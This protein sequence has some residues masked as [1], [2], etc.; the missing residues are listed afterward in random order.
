MQI[1]YE[2]KLKWGRSKEKPTTIQPKRDINAGD[3]WGDII[4][5]RCT[6]KTPTYSAPTNVG[7]EVGTKAHSSKRFWEAL[8]TQGLSAEECWPDKGPESDY[9]AKPL[10]PLP[11]REYHN[12]TYTGPENPTPRDIRVQHSAYNILNLRTL[13][14]R[15]YTLPHTMRDAVTQS[16]A[17]GMKGLSLDNKLYFVYKLTDLDKLSTHQRI[18]K[19]AG[20]VDMFT[21]PRTKFLLNVIDKAVWD[22][23]NKDLYGYLKSEPVQRRLHHHPWSARTNLARARLTKKPFVY[24]DPLTI[25]DSFSPA[26]GYTVLAGPDGTRIVKKLEDLEVV[27]PEQ[28]K[29][30]LTVCKSD[31]IGINH[32]DWKNHVVANNPSWYLKH[33]TPCDM[34][35]VLPAAAKIV[36][37]ATQLKRALVKHIREGL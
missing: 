1:S 18:L 23:I 26:R 9:H 3:T 31:Y 35:K 33:L 30:T 15:V 21:Y 36:D 12:S 20:L 13:D 10:Y 19:K 16:T 28:L 25:H 14:R 11:Y 34:L 8:F 2:K 17:L 22:S 37:Y 27:T 6:P 5:N 29:E 7:I 4:E 24:F 32:S